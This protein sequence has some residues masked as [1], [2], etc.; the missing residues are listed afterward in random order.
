MTAKS[1]IQL[2]PIGHEQAAAVNRYSYE[3]AACDRCKRDAWAPA[4]SHR[5]ANA[6]RLCFGCL[7]RRRADCAREARR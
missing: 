5:A 4:D 6:D 2:I 7:G 1:T 3:L